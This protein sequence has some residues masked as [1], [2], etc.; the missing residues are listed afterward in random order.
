[1]AATESLVQVTEGTGKKL[2]TNQRTIGAN[3]VEDEYVLPGEFPYAS[4]LVYPLTSTSTAGAANDHILTI[5]AGAS[6]KVRIRRIR[7]EQ[8][9]NATTATLLALQIM[10]TTTAAPTG[11]TAVTPR[12]HDSADAAAGFT[13]MTLP[14]VKATEGVM[15]IRTV[16]LMRQAISATQSQPDDA[17]EWTQTPGTPPIIIPAG[18]ANGICIKIEAAVAAGSLICSAECT[19][20]SF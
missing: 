19:E 17:W 4:Y 2:H 14:T 9:A 8:A 6:L 15:L 5:N 18:T 13:A 7:I 3:N 11:G 20:T 16:L 12:P 10:R 1:M